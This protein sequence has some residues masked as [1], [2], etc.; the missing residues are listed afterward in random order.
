MDDGGPSLPLGSSADGFRAVALTNTDGSH[1]VLIRDAERPKALLTVGTD[2][3]AGRV[4]V[5][6]LADGVELRKDREAAAQWIAA[7]S[8]GGPYAQDGARRKT[9]GETGP[10]TRRSGGVPAWADVIGLALVL[11]I[12]ALTI[13]GVLTVVGWLSALLGA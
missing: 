12:F 3:R 6:P 5:T 11:A 4:L 9:S 2:A 13:L 10:E 8:V 7:G 1:A